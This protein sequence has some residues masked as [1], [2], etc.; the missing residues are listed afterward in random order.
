MP[1]PPLTFT[2]DFDGIK[3][4]AK[5]VRFWAERPTDLSDHSAQLSR[6]GRPIILG[7]LDPTDVS[8][9]MEHLLGLPQHR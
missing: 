1:K 2:A 4:A 5:G 8:R 6:N 7:I 9:I 3:D